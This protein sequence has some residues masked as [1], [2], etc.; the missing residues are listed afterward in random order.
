[1]IG[2]SKFIKLVSTDVKVLGTIFVYADVIILGLDIGTEIGSLYGYFDSSNDGKLDILFLGYS[3]V[4]N[5]GKV[6][7]SDECIQL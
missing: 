5:G 6:L 3:L 2:S 7:G 4:Y 1:M